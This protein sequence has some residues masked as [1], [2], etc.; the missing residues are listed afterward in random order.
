[1]ADERTRFFRLACLVKDYRDIRGDHHAGQ[2]KSPERCRGDFS[3]LC[4]PEVPT[5][6]NFTD[7]IV[8]QFPPW[9]LL[10][11]DLGVMLIEF[12]LAGFRIGF[13]IYYVL[14]LFYFHLILFDCF[15]LIRATFVPMPVFFWTITTFRL[16]EGNFSIGPSSP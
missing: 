5:P 1:M 13:L 16:L 10:V 15:L 11:R 14:S 6:H 12:P 8:H 3:A 2:E 9:F 7:P 4:I